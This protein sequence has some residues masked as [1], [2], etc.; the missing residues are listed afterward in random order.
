MRAGKN[1]HRSGDRRF[2]GKKS[3][4]NARDVRDDGVVREVK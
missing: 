1:R 3:P 4:R 2:A